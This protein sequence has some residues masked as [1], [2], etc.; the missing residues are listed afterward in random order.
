MNFLVGKT[1]AEVMVKIKG[2][3]STGLAIIRKAKV[4][5]WSLVLLKIYKQKMESW[6]IRLIHVY[7]IFAVWLFYV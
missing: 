1:K 3:L 4:S 6:E 2:S 5:Y 7:H